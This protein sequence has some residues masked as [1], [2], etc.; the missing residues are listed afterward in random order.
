LK[1]DDLERLLKQATPPPWKVDVGG[2]V[3]GY[4]EDHDWFFARGPIIRNLTYQDATAKAERDGRFMSAA[5]LHMGKLLEIVKAYKE[6][7]IVRLATV[8]KLIEELETL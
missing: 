7:D 1:L 6:Q 4:E 8:D 3:T 5:S 2:V